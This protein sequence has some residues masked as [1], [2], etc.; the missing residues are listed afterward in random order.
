M[1]FAVRQQSFRT[2]VTPSSHRCPQCRE[3]ALMLQRRHVSP[4]RL[5][6]PLVTEFYDCDCCDA[7]Y[8]YSPAENRWRE[9]A[10]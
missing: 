5:G 6:E 8:K 1:D 9:L 7:R 4:E 2:R 3:Q 10:T